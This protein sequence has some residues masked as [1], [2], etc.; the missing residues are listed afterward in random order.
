[1]TAITTNPG[2]ITIG[3]ATR[4]VS[5]RPTP[6]RNARFPVSQVSRSRVSRV[7]YLRHRLTVAVL[8]LG[9]VV[10]VAQAG[11]ALGGDPLSSSERTPPSGAVSSERTVV[12]RSGD[13]L[14]S[15]VSRL[16]PDQDPRPLVDDLSM[17]RNGAPLIPGEVISL[18]Q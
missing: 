14:W 11:S 7:T 16:A 1:M 2:F 15:I 13:S 9:L 5:S 10:M 8:A 18:D 17:A 4:R 12:V 6:R 3:P